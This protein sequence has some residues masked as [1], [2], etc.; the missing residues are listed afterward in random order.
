MSDEEQGFGAWRTEHHN[1]AQ[2]HA[3]HWAEQAT[4]EYEQAVRHEDDARER[5]QYDSGWQRDRAA[6][7]RSLA[8]VHGV[9]STEALRLAEMWART[10]QALAH[11]ELPI[12]YTAVL[13]TTESAQDSTTP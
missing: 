3:F 12:E 1:R 2:A 4:S 11:G 13:G 6:E 10:A 7:A 5:Q 9:R 8:Q